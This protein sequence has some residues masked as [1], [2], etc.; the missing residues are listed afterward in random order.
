[1]ASW[2]LLCLLAV[3]AGGLAGCATQDP[4]NL[5]ARPWNTPRS[6]EHGLPPEMLEGR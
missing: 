2:L 3:I 6:W 1:V 4:D 5:S